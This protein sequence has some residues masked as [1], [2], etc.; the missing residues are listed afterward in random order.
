[1]NEGAAGVTLAGWRGSSR[2]PSSANCA[3]VPVTGAC[4]YYLGST[5]N[6]NIGCNETSY[7]FAAADTTVYTGGYLGNWDLAFGKFTAMRY[8]GLCIATTTPATTLQAQNIR[9]WFY[10]TYNVLP[11]V[12]D[13]VV[14]IGDSRGMVV[15]SDLNANSANI[16][17]AGENIAVQLASGLNSNAEVINASVSGFTN[18]NHA[19]STIPSLVATYRAG[20][21]I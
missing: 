18:A 6:V 2:T 14:F 11:Q 19:T 4:A 3:P 21:K 16:G 7:N 17:S 15:Y 13:R 10:T 8:F 9:H 12:R 1:M 5:G 20:V